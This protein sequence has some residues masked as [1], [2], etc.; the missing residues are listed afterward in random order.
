MVSVNTVRLLF[1][2]LGVGLGLLSFFLR[3]LTDPLFSSSLPHE[4]DT[5]FL[6]LASLGGR[7]NNRGKL[8]GDKM[9]LSTPR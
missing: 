6:A 5:F 4:L 2:Q 1:A 8:K 9:S 3:L 7:Q